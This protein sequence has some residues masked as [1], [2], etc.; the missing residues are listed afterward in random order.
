[1]LLSSLDIQENKH[2]LGLC[3]S[4]KGIGTRLEANV[5]TEVFF[6][7]QQTEGQTETAERRLE[8]LNVSIKRRKQ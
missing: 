1:M 7:Y 5:L 6:F 8:N 2:T 3:G 4:M